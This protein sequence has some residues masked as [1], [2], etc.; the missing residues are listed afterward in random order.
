M[1]IREIHDFLTPEDSSESARFPVRPPDGTK[2]L[3]EWAHPVLVFLTRVLEAH[4]ASLSDEEA[5]AAQRAV[6]RVRELFRLAEECELEEGRLN[7]FAREAHQ[8][9]GVLHVQDH[10]LGALVQ[11]YGGM[12]ALNTREIENIPCAEIR[13]HH[14]D[15]ANGES[16][17][18]WYNE[19]VTSETDIRRWAEQLEHQTPEATQ[20][21]QAPR[22]PIID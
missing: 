2:S 7:D 21:L 5:L 9:E 22:G 1:N 19:G 17:L 18:V 8:L 4:E 12:L 15:L 11:R 16:F 3:S 10:V 13:S 14:I 6:Q 20:R